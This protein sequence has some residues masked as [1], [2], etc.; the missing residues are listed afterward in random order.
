MVYVKGSYKIEAIYDIDEN[1]Q[2]EP[3]DIFHA[4]SKEFSVKSLMVDL[5]K[6][7]E[8]VWDK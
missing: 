1:G 3:E 5:E 7:E 8:V 4:I 6:E 2:M